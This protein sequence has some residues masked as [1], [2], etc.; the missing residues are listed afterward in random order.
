MIP[1]FKVKMSEEAAK[2]VSDVL[3][4]GYVTQG[5][6]VEEFEELLWGELKT[7]TKPIV[8]NSCTSAINLALDLCDVDFGDEVIS[9]AQ[10]CFASNV[11]AMHKGAKIRWADIDPLTGLI[12][13]ESVEKLITDKTKAIIAVNWSGKF[14]DY[15]TLKS[16]GIPVIE[17]A[18]HTWD[19]FLDEKPE[20]GD[21]ICYSLQAIKFLTS[22]DGGILIAPKNKEND[23]R[24][25]RWYGL[26]RTKNESFRCTQNIIKAGFKYN[27]NDVSAAIGISNIEEAKKS[28]ID[29]RANAKYFCD[30]LK[31]LDFIESPVFEDNHSYWIF[32]LLLK[33]G[34]D[35]DK[36]ISYLEKNNIVASQVHFRNDL[37]D[38]TIKYKE[39]DLPGLDYFTNN[40]LNIPV[41]WWLTE[42]DRVH[43]VDTIKNWNGTDD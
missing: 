29:H 7:E 35:R 39:Q 20:R 23:A 14:A 5:P 13:P 8:V 4:S 43:I 16:F 36:F 2:N 38:S 30:N 21:Y 37:Y 42:E 33:S 15:K 27:M 22:S 41:G 17:D 10:T 28:V 32:P 26:D 24:M 40:Q 9:T 12:D 1:L 19:A 3:F 11:G 31:D 34:Y 25:L 6:K 18:A